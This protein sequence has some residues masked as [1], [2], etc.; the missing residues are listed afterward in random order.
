[1]RL[2]KNALALINTSKARMLIAIA[3]DC[4][5]MSVRRYIDSNDDNLTK[6]AALQVIREETGLTDQEILEEQAEPAKA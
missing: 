3:L 5:E 1:M 2:T 4:S 6:A